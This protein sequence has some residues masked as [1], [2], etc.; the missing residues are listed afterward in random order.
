MVLYLLE[1]KH[2]LYHYTN[3]PE[4]FFDQIGSNHICFDYMRPK[5]QLDIDEITVYHK[6]VKKKL[7]GKNKVYNNKKRAI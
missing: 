7:F 1:S 4:D 3:L 6:I 5:H 2:L